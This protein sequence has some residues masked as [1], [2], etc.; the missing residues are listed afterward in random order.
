MKMTG[1]PAKVFTF[2]ASLLVLPTFLAAA[3][4]DQKQ[5]A[6]GKTAVAE[7][8]PSKSS[9]SAN[10][11]KWTEA[12]GNLPLA[13]EKNLGQTDPQVQ[14]LS[15]G[16]GYE[17]FL[18]PAETVLALHHAQP[19]ETSPLTRP[20]NAK[21]F[22]ERLS[23]EKAS[24]IRIQIKGANPHPAVSGLDKLPGKTD[25]FI[26][27]NP[28][29]WRTDVPS[30]ARVQY[31]DVY[32]G[33]DLVF[34]GNN[35][36]FEYDY[37]VAPGADP[38]TIALN[39]TGER[40]LSIDHD[41]NLMMHFDNG[42]VEMRKPVVYQTVN[43]E[44]HEV[45]ARYV[46][47][48]KDQVSFAVGAYDKAQP[49]V[50]DP[51]VSYSTYLGGSTPFGDVANG[52]AVDAAGNAYVTGQTFSSTFPTVG[53]YQTS[54]SMNANGSVFVTEMNPAGTAVLYSTYLSGTG[55][56]GELGTGIA[57]DPAPSAACLNG[58]SAP[59]VCMYV[60]GLT[61][62]T[63]FPTTSNGLIQSPLGSSS[64]TAFISKIN[65]A[66]SGMASLVY[67]SYI[68]GTN[69]DYANGIAVDANAN[70]YVAGYTNSTPGSGAGDFAV[71]GGFQSTLNSPNGNAFLIRI[72]TT[73]SGTPSLIYS[74]YLGG[75]GTGSGTIGVGDS[76]LGVA[77]DSAHN[78]YITGVTTS[79][80]FPTTAANAYVPTLNLTGGGGGNT[81]FVA[82]IDTTQTGMAS[83]IYSTYLASTTATAPLNDL[84]NAITL[85]PG[86]VAYVTGQ[87]S[88]NVF[89]T[90]ESGSTAGQ[91][92][93]PPS[94]A[95]VV[96]VSLI[97]TTKSG[98]NSLTYST[99]LGGTGGDNGL[100]IRTDGSGNAYVTGV[101]VSQN[102]PITAGAYQ[103]MLLNTTYGDA[104]IAEIA[105]NGNGAADLI[106]STYFGGSD[107][108]VPDRAYGIALD[109][110][111][112]VYIAGQTGSDNFPIYPTG[113]AYQPSLGGMN[114]AAGFV[115]KLTLEP[116]VVVSPATLNFTNQVVG[117][118]STAQTVTLTNNGNVALTISAP[119]SASMDFG[120]TSEHLQRLDCARGHL[121]G[122][123]DV[124]SVD[125][126]ERNRHADF[127]G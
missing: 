13:F 15:R 110:S 122:G 14:F 115:A 41:G 35:R 120:T 116:T 7:S 22:R 101:A 31:H 64:G 100:G 11:R 24:V 105:P 79:S 19:G 94:G 49:L 75:S 63:D 124:H 72:D 9:S 25:Y 74:T 93:S 65:P 80:D 71:V 23:S 121:H 10:D 30:Y 60:T 91:F 39:V 73:Q 81:A 36:H 102:F 78:A 33:I 2:V 48:A 43:G 47:A 12:Y 126:A 53:A 109:S 44:H 119:P 37:V 55:A 26:G 82:R 98:T 29:N 46:L 87:T 92:P 108:A 125:H 86:N 99:L 38:Q 118:T 54:S 104:F 68:G 50:I 114:V 21:E 42:S 57:V 77:V 1:S 96:F 51:V 61:S 95:G 52:I 90:T 112:N 103:N 97:D 27:S 17:I 18:T 88:S 117:I 83:L 76:G 28:K 67:S 107:G 85:G 4:N 5:P 111:K 58:S 89:P 66:L 20:I 69:G 6:S 56:N 113:S 123:R 16:S 40:K 62:S 34:Y 59:G 127:H 32:P 8:A 106:Y 3:P 84:G 70:A 45:A